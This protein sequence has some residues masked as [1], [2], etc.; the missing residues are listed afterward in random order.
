M[1]KSILSIAVIL[2][3]TVLTLSAC[4]DPDKVPAEL[5]IQGAEQVVS[6]AKTEIGQIAPEEVQAVETALTAAKEKFAKGEYKAALAEAQAVVNKTTDVVNAAK[7]K[8]EAAKA[9]LAELTQKWTELSEG[10]PKMVEALQSRVDIL[11]KSRKL[12][13]TLTKEQFAEAK[14]GLAAATEEWN[15]AQESFKAGNLEEAISVATSVK[16]KA[17]K[18][19]EA[20]GMTAPEAAK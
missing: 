3:F 4:K 20:L 13:K 10:L 14:D 19:M 8:A 7:A 1:K 17:S 18:A 6:A 5:A 12:P 11:S 16:D 9:K 2:L 15:K